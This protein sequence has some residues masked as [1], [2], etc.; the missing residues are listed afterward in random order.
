MSYRRSG[1]PGSASR[2]P[3]RLSWTTLLLVVSSSCALP[4]ASHSGHA[5]API[6]AQHRTA[7]ADHLV[8]R[9]AEPETETTKPK[10]PSPAEL[11]S[12]LHAIRKR[13]PQ[14]VDAA[15]R[16]KYTQWMLATAARLRDELAA[17]RS[18]KE[19]GD[20]LAADPR[21]AEV[22]WPSFFLVQTTPWDFPQMMAVN[23]SWFVWKDWFDRT[24]RG[25]AQDA[26]PGGDVLNSAFFVNVDVTSYTPERLRADDE[27]IRPHGNITVTKAKTSGTAEGF[28]G[29]DERGVEYIFVFDPPFDPEMVTA[30]EQIGSTL[31]RIAGYNVPKT[32]VCRVR[33]TGTREYDG[34]RAVATVALEGFR[35]GWTYRANR[36]RRVLRGLRVLAAWLHN[37]DQTSHN[38]AHSVQPS[39]IA[40]PYIFDFGASLGSFTYRPKW[41]R[42]GDHYLFAPSDSL[43]RV[44]SRREWSDDFAIYSPAVGQFPQQVD[45][46]RWRPF[47]RNFA[48][49]SATWQD[50]V[51]GAKLLAQFSDEQIRTVVELAHF[52]HT[53]DAEYVA[54]RLIERRDQLVNYYLT[55][56][57]AQ[58]IAKAKRNAAKRR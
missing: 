10:N 56:E 42:L 5:P 18:P 53:D 25:P 27:Q 32:S 20:S 51:W 16:D 40:V 47:Y 14:P 29:T 9:G 23:H 21:C 28:F 7:D 19:I 54:R 34:R 58:I 52:S 33:G 50:N 36:N 17:G 43:L 2:S 39:G 55:S 57:T 46:A 26:L 11:A 49:E 8:A 13:A 1:N 30:A 6:A 35:D 44:L 31:M 12:V 41:P 4:G 48:F 37:V 38:T 24:G 15:R 22:D 45:P 3:V